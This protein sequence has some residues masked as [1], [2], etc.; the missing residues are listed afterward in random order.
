[1]TARPKEYRMPTAMLTAA[2]YKAQN[3]RRMMREMRSV[4]AD[5]LSRQSVSKLKKHLAKISSASQQLSKPN[6]IFFKELQVRHNGEPVC[7]ELASG[8]MERAL[9]D[10]FKTVWRINPDT[11]F[12]LCNAQFAELSD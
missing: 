3:L 11:R 4:L 12:L 7:L 10:T 6:Q 9:P 1:M 2:S 8:K 5:F